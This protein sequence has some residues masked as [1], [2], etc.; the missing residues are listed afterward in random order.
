MTTTI[1]EGEGEKRDDGDDDTDNDDSPWDAA[2]NRSSRRAEVK[3][4]AIA[5]YICT[6]HFFV[7][8]DPMY[9]EVCFKYYY[10]YLINYSSYFCIIIIVII[11][12]I[13]LYDW[14]LSSRLKLHI[15]YMLIYAHLKTFKHFKI[16]NKRIFLTKNF[17]LTK[18]CI[19][20]KNVNDD[21][22]RNLE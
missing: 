1:D 12:I 22:R 6:N 11:I 9:M 4:V 16:K 15:I 10:Y 13:V 8:M 17:K 20:F 5:E 7:W 3:G 18:I 21:I 14:T 2:S 19:S